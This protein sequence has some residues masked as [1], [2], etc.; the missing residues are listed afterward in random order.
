MLRCQRVWETM[1]G[2]CPCF[3]GACVRVCRFV[4]TRAALRQIPLFFWLCC[5]GPQSQDGGS[6][7]AALATVSCDASARGRP[8]WVSVAPSVGRLCVRRFVATLMVLGRSSFSGRLPESVILISQILSTLPAPSLKRMS[9][10]PNS[11]YTE[12]F[13]FLGKDIHYH[14]GSSPAPVAHQVLCAA[15]V[16]R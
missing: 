10:S 2:F 15:A 3:G 1:L 12:G 16:G 7:P 4:A 11:V 8:R 6:R 5:L 9:F 14:C 13:W